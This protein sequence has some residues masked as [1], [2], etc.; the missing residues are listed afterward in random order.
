[1]YDVWWLGSISGAV[2]VF[3]YFDMFYILRHHLAKKGLRNK[4]YM[5]EW[6]NFENQNVDLQ[7]NIYLRFVLKA[8]GLNI[9]LKVTWKG[10][11]LTLRF[12]T[13]SS[14]WDR[15]LLLDT[16]G[17]KN[18]FI[19]SKQTCDNESEPHKWKASVLRGNTTFINLFD[20]HVS[21]VVSY[22]YNDMGLHTCIQIYIFT[23][24]ELQWKYKFITFWETIH[25]DVCAGK[26]DPRF[27]SRK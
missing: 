16:S 1:M 7:W 26:P 23:K 25:T 11:N 18:L 4:V 5:N 27:L 20:N 14:F 12:L 22:I 17:R 13:G 6:M 21:R 3:M 15:I 24:M 8:V 2:Y 10:N 9:R 19:F